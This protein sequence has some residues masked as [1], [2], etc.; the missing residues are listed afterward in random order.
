MLAEWKNTDAEHFTS[1]DSL[2]FY[3]QR[4]IDDFLTAVGSD[5]KPLIDGV[6]GRKTVELI[7][8]I[9]RSARQNAVI[10]FPL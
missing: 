4:Q 7:T 2:Y 5:T 9:Y 1:A 10:K 6:D 3:H 8:A